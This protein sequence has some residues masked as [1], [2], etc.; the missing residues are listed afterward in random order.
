MRLFIS[1]IFFLTGVAFAESNHVHLD[2]APTNICDTASLQRGAGVFMQY[3]Q[4]CHSLQYMRYQSLAEG[5]GMRDDKGVVL[6]DLIK[7]Q[8]NFV[9]D[10]SVDPIRAAMPSKDA[11]KWF[12]VAPPDLTLVA[13]VRGKDWLYTYLRQFY[14][15]PTRPWGV[16]NMAFPA[17]GM[18]HVMQHLQGVQVPVYKTISVMEQGHMVEKQVID[19]LI[20][21]SPGQLSP[22]A[23]DR[24]ITDLV[25][26]LEYAAEPARRDREH[27]GVWV[28]LFLVVFLLFAWLLKREYWKDIKKGDAD[29]G[30]K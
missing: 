21:Q 17:V 24:T 2:V 3:C 6:E 26:F 25:N 4:G 29:V 30:N 15:D 11:E 18:P 1:A 28:M 13:R 12:G 16:N 27:L 19:H 20:L 22:A 9:T 5:I 10:K 23:Y 7:S 14:V 8:L